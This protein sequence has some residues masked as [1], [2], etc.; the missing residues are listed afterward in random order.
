MTAV[1]AEGE[2]LAS[3]G[4]NVKAAF[5]AKLAHTI[6]I[7]G[8]FTYTPETEGL[9]KPTHLRR[10]NEVQHRVIACLVEVLD[11]QCSVE[12][13]RT[14]AEWVLR[15]PDAEL[16][17]PRKSSKGLGL[18]DAHPVALCAIVQGT[19]NRKRSG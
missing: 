2:W 15:Q 17:R 3:L 13:Q 16:L 9:D 5:L 8:R 1:E 11:D 7:A 10:I 18:E 12:F 6:T 14:I 19:I 4:N